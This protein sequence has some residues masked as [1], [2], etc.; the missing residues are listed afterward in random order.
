MISELISG[1]V[2]PLLGEG[3]VLDQSIYSKDERAQN[4]TSQTNAEANLLN[5]QAALE[6]ARNGGNANNSKTN[7]SEVLKYILF[8][9]VAIILLIILIVAFR[10][11]FAKS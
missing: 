2:G 11:L 4:A 8:G 1:I 6:F 7:Q 5:A 3:G 9:F 10:W